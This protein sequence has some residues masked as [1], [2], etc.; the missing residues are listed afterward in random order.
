MA[1]RLWRVWVGSALWV[2][3]ALALTWCGWEWHESFETQ[4]RARRWLKTAPVLHAPVAQSRLPRLRRGDV[5]AELGIPR[6]HVSV[7]VLEGDDAGILKLAAGHIPGTGL[8]Q[9]SG[10]IGIAA[11]RD[12]FFRPLRFIRNNDI[13]TLKTPAGLSRFAVSDMEVVR[14]VDTTVLSPAPRRDL[15]LITCY[16]F[17]YLGSAPKRF[18]VHARRLA[19]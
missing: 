8:P 1:T 3:G 15:T 7:M 11:H 5:V 13:I 9:S 2:M 18:V 6:L 16:P 4:A 10:N 14:P 17:F 19:A 12:S